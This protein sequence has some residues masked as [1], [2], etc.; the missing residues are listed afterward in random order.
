[1]LFEMVAQVSD[2]HAHAKVT[3]VK[4]RN[5]A[6]Q[7]VLDAWRVKLDQ[8]SFIDQHG[9]PYCS[10]LLPTQVAS[11]FKQ[12]VGQKETQVQLKVSK[13]GELVWEH[14]RIPERF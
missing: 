13:S 1:M 10:K 6:V 9:A 14:R 5:K 3:K 8:Y 2:S 4:D 7:H 12:A 11:C